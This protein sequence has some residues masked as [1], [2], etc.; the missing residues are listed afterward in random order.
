MYPSHNAHAAPRQSE[1]RIRN[2]TQVTSRFDT[3]EMANMPRRLLATRPISAPP[4]TS[5]S[6]QL[7]EAP[8][9]GRRERRSLRRDEGGRRGLPTQHQGRPV[10][11]RQRI[12]HGDRRQR[13]V[14][15]SGVR[16][17]I[18]TRSTTVPEP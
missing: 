6:R 12:D 14:P 18:P 13:R 17:A 4:L 5:I 9:H 1:P 11:Y 2:A 7:A 15:R 16:S 10:D 3:S 8:K